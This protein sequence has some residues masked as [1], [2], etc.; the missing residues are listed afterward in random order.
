MASVAKTIKQ[1]DRQTKALKDVV[2]PRL[3]AAQ[4]VFDTIFPPPKKR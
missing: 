1:I 2:R 4:K 3:K